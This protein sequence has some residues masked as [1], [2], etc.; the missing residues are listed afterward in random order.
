MKSSSSS[1]SLNCS[2]ECSPPLRPPPSPPMRMPFSTFHVEAD[3]A[4][5][6]AVP[7]PAG[8]ADPAGAPAPPPRPAAT[9]QPDRY[10]PLNSCFHGPGACA[11]VTGPVQATPNSNTIPN[12]SNALPEST[13]DFICGPPGAVPSIVQHGFT[14]QEM[15]EK[16]AMFEKPGPTIYDVALSDNGERDDPIPPVCFDDC[17]TFDQAHG[18][19][20]RCRPG[21]NCPPG[22]A[23]SAAK[24]CSVQGC[25]WPRAEAVGRRAHGPEPHG[26]HRRRARPGVGAGRRELPADATQ[27]PGPPA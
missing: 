9:V 2:S 16:N 20:G 25:T 17:S 15:F 18:A 5:A 19:P 22:P 26:P 23:G 24:C 8:A 11:H 27:P 3:G 12:P 1:K 10:L 14:W 21:G 4:G 13:I 6:A 7:A